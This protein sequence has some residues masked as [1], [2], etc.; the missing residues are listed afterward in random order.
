VTD[1]TPVSPRNILARAKAREAVNAKTAHA[2]QRLSD[3]RKKGD[4]VEVNVGF[5]D[6]HRQ[7]RSR[8]ALTRSCPA[9]P[10][11]L[12]TLPPHEVTSQQSDEPTANTPAL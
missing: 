6:L 8:S 5:S 1:T 3:D 11:I 2:D 10:M 7:R 12:P 4:I 9:G